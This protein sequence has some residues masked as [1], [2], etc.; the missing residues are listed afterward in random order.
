MYTCVPV[1]RENQIKST[2]K[3]NGQ[4]YWKLTENSLL[5]HKNFVFGQADFFLLVLE[6][7]S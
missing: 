7:L 5:K 1:M 6:R 4:K 2:T 3:K